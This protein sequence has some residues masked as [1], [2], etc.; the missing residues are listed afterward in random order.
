LAAGWFT[1]AWTI[2]P[3]SSVLAI[4]L[5]VTNPGSGSLTL[6]VGGLSWPEN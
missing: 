4:G 6:A 2:P 5:Q 1:L 3:A